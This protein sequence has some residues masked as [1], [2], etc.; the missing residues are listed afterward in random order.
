MLMQC[1]T[2]TSYNTDHGSFLPLL[3]LFVPPPL[4]FSQNPPHPL[5]IIREHW[6][7]KHNIHNVMSGSRAQIPT[8]HGHPNL[9]TLHSKCQLTPAMLLQGFLVRF[10]GKRIWERVWAT[11]EYPRVTC[12]NHHSWVNETVDGLVHILHSFSIKNILA[13]CCPTYNSRSHCKRQIEE[14]PKPCCN[15][16]FA[17]LKAQ[18]HY[19]SSSHGS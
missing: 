18:S 1:V 4:N 6:G 16:Q 5:V 11:L 2:K 13:H 7:G 3:L 14:P 15:L 9:A 19:S 17:L 10:G 12:E 8:C